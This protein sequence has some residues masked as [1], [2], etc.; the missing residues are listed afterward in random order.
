MNE[1]R[2]HSMPMAHAAQSSGARNPWSRPTPFMWICPDCGK[3]A[4]TRA[5]MTPR[6]LS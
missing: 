1:N 6:S 2:Y 4:W 3:L 5:L